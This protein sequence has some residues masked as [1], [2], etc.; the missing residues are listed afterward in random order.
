MAAREAHAFPCQTPVLHAPS[1]FYAIRRF[2]SSAAEAASEEEIAALY[3]KWETL[4]AEL[5]EAQA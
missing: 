3:T 5:E 4:A 2:A 1:L